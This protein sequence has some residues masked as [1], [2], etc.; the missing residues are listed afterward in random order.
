MEGCLES[1]GMCL[2]SNKVENYCSDSA[3]WWYTL[4]K[5]QTDSYG[6]C[7][8][9]LNCNSL[10]DYTSTDNQMSVSFHPPTTC[11][12][13]Q[14]SPQQPTSI[15]TSGT[16]PPVDHSKPSPLPVLTSQLNVNYL[17]VLITPFS[18]PCL[19]LKQLIK[20][21]DCRPLFPG[22]FYSTAS[23]PVNK[24]LQLCIVFSGSHSE[25]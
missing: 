17:S 6:K 4:V 3:C 8:I 9:R 16:L 1:N 7:C 11:L 20:R 19:G 24:M 25:K 23:A 2:K 15:L 5:L 21:S 14:A 22:Y 18:N 10:V 13:I 12:I